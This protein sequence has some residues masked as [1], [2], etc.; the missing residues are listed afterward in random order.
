MN[1]LFS[2]YLSNTEKA[3]TYSFVLDLLTDLGHKVVVLCKKNTYIELIT[4]EYETQEDIENLKQNDFNLILAS[5]T[6]SFKE[7]KNISRQAGIPIIGLIDSREYAFEKIARHYNLDKIVLLDPPLD[8][9][10]VF[11][12]PGFINHW[13]LPAV[14]LPTITNTNSQHRDPMRP[15][16]VVATEERTDFLSPIFQLIPFLNRLSNFEIRLVTENKGIHKTLNSNIRIVSM[17]KTDLPQ[18]LTESDIVVASGRLAEQTIA[19]N[20]PVIIAGERGYGGILSE[21]IFE[22]Q[23]QSQF[24]GRI[25]GIPGEYIPEKLLMEDILDLMECGNDR[26]NIITQATRQKLKKKAEEQKT[27]L[28]KLLRK[29]VKYHQELKNNL[30]EASLNLS[31]AWQLKSFSKERFVLLNT[32]T[33]QVHSYFETEEKA[34]IELFREGCQVKEALEASE[35]S[36]EPELFMNFIR[37]LVNEKILIVDGSN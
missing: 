1:I 26:I 36:E 32:I 28:N 3:K 13:R 24:Q 12:Q 9:P 31:D 14:F 20:K 4:K 33:G 17:S 8:Y 6:S 2:I 30:T 22:L 11:L 16:M 23:Y 21:D 25:G 19:L 29:M 15:R 27:V 5:D 35:Y 18:L 10:K 7:L 34:I 37:N